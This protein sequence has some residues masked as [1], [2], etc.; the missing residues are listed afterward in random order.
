[1]LFVLAA[2]L[3]LAVQA[4]SAPSELQSGNWRFSETVSPLDGRRTVTQMLLSSNQVR[5]ITG[6]P[7]T[8]VFMLRCQDGETT[9]AIS[10]AGA[11]FGSG[12]AAVAWRVNEGAIKREQ[13]F[14]GRGQSGVAG[15][16]RAASLVASIEGGGR[17]VIQVEGRRSTDD[18]VFELGDSRRAVETVRTAC[19]KSR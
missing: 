17:M 7:V 2:A 13:W 18:V 16:T 3:A 14:I 8:A 6:Q 11:Y 5:G 19:T 4:P 9:A 1:M 15:T 10:W 12:S